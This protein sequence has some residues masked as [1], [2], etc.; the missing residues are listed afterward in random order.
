MSKDGFAGVPISKL[1]QSKTF[2]S[3]TRQKT[4]KY[5]SGVYPTASDSF[6][7][8]SDLELASFYNSLWFYYHCEGEYT[9]NDLG[10]LTGRGD[11]TTWDK[12]PCASEYPLPYTPQGLLYNFYTYQKF[13]VN[14]IRS[15]SDPSK[16]WLQPKYAGSTR[17]G[18]MGRYMNRNTRP[19]GIMWL[20]P[21]TIHRDVWYPN[22]LDNVKQLVEGLPDNWKITVGKTPT[23]NFPDNWYGKL[24]DNAFLE[25]TH[26]PANTGDAINQSPW[27]WYNGCPGSGMF[28][29]FGKTLAVKTKA[30][31]VFELSRIL[32]QSKDGRELLMKWFNSIDPYKICWGTLGLCGYNSVTKQNYCDFSKMACGIACGPV[33]IGY[34]NAA[35]IKL[36]NFY[37][38]TK[39]FGVDAHGTPTNEAIHKAIDAAVNNTDYYLAHISVNLLPDELCFFLGMNVGIDTLQFYEDPSPDDEYVF[40]IIDFRLPDRMREKAKNRDYSDFLNIVDPGAQPW[41]TAATKNSYKEAAIREYLEFMYDNEFLSVR[42]PLDIHNESKIQKC[43]GTKLEKVC[44]GQYARMQYCGNI[45]LMDRW[46][47]LFM[48]NEFNGNTCKLHGSNPTC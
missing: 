18:I 2:Y 48:G 19:S 15:D 47:C 3:D 5:L 35:N 36:Q 23:Y 39:K 24:G 11:D 7:K 8:L 10:S 41:S 38:E 40:E 37:E 33:E 20:P 12:L 25:V 34:A 43:K 27:W 29:K 4:L 32:A 22:G 16:I 46:K 30:G 42:D 28:L 26:S 13:N 1:A 31:G 21:R 9:D 14:K 6:S 17:P 45:P 44:D